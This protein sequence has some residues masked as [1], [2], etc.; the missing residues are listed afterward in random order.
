M[1][2]TSKLEI[3]TSEAIV[4]SEDAEMVTL[5]SVEGQMGILPQYVALM[6]QLI[7]GGMIV[8][9]AGRDEILVL[10]EGLVEVTGKRVSVLTDMAVAALFG[11]G[12]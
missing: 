5:T 1:A 3:V 6:T 4:Y 9:K 12:R 2:E 8:R 7:P 10:G 11:S